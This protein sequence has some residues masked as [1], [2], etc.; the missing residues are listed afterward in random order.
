MPRVGWVRVALFWLPAIA[1]VSIGCGGA[2]FVPPPADMAP[3]DAVDIFITKG[4]LPALAVAII[5]GGQT[6]YTKVAGIRKRGDATPVADDDAFHIGS[7]TK[8]MTALIAGTVV[9]Q[10]LLTWDSTVGDVLGGTVDVGGYGAVTLAQ[11][12]SHSSGIPEYP[13]QVEAAI[14]AETM[15]VVEAQRREAASAA[16]ALPPASV[17]GTSFLYSSGNFVIAGLMLELATSTSWEDLMAQRLFVP[18]G[19]THAGYG[20][21]GTPGMVDAPWGHDPAPIDP[22]TPDIAPGAGPAGTVHDSL[23]DLIAYAQLYLDDGVGPNGRIISDA[24]LTAMETPRLANYGF[25]WMTGRSDTGVLRMVHSGSNRR[26][27][28]LMILFPERQ[29]AMLMLTNDGTQQSWDR[30]D[31]VASYFAAHFGLP[32]KGPWA[33]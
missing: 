17:A 9:D 3:D 13:S 15:P 24:A 6:L 33:S 5:D 10:G 4:D 29:G 1:A 28:S 2:D 32:P 31:Q 25:G 18:L 21:P 8:G 30:V 22:G 20:L 7:N 19:M 11:L 23:G 14:D 27:Y 26:F 12:L 16:L